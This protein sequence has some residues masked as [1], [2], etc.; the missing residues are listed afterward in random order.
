MRPLLSLF[1]FVFCVAA[2]CNS[3][4]QAKEDSA[5]KAAKEQMM[6]AEGYQAAT[7]VVQAE[8]S[9]CPVVLKLENEYVDPIDLKDEFKTDQL[10]VWVKFSRLRRMNRCDMAGPV[11][12]TEIQKKAE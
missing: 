2:S 9:G 8:S 7:V 4:Q 1:A 10:E 6:T 12:I 3:G 5:A 11:S